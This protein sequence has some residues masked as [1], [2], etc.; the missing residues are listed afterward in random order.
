MQVAPAAS[1]EG[2]M[3]QLLELSTKLELT[4]MPDMVSAVDWLFVSVT[5]FAPELVPIVVFCH[6]K[7]LGEKPIDGLVVDV[8]PVPVKEAV[9]G[10]P[11]ALSLTVSAPFRV[12]VVVGS[13]DTM[14]S[15]LLFAASVFGLKGQFVEEMKSDRLVATEEMVTAVV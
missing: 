12:P 13:N 14:M 15:Q 3:G 5:L 10:E 4:V 2:E 6:D 1:V 11:E 7:E 8:V 9:A